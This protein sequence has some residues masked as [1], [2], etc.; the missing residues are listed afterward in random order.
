MWGGIP[1]AT[2]QSSAALLRCPVLLYPEALMGPIH[3]RLA[4][5]LLSL[6]TACGAESGGPTESLPPCAVQGTVIPGA[7]ASGHIGASNCAGMSDIPATG[8]TN[9]VRWSVTIHPDTIYIVS[10]RLLSPGNG[11]SWF[12]KLLAYSGEGGDTLLRTGF[13]GWAHRANGDV[14]EEMLVADTAD[15]QLILHL[16]RAT[17]SDS[18]NYQ[19]EVRRCAMIRLTP[20]VTTPPLALDG[21]CPLWT[22]GSPGRAIF[23]DYPS[24]AAVTRQVTVDQLG[25]NVN[26]YYAWA[27]APRIN[28]ACW[29]AGGDCNLGVGGSASFAITPSPV[30]GLTGGALFTLGPVATVTLKV[31]AVP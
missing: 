2:D 13:W 12:G 11:S 30:D 7:T 8:A 18:G 9:F 19:L 15:R 29:Y 17:L 31:D 3:T 25:G 21:G 14:L 23:F 4:P 24:T 20:G 28:F 22:A 6:L 27:S 1:T 16:E 5:L 10:A 26:L